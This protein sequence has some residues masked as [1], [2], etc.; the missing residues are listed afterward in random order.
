MKLYIHTYGSMTS[1]FLLS[2]LEKSEIT[3]MPMLSARQT[4]T[5]YITDP[6]LELIS[7]KTVLECAVNIAGPH[8]VFVSVEVLP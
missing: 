8:S 3:T 5:Q 1:L 2:F 6:A 4:Q 7:H